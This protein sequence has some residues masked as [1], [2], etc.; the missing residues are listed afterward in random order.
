MKVK[1]TPYPEMPIDIR[2]TTRNNTLED[3]ILHNHC[4]ENIKFYTDVLC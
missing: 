3:K 2:R 1:V 4:C